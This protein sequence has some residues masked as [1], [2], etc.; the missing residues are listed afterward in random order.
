MDSK[1][2]AVGELQQ[3]SFEQLE[4]YNRK[5]RD[6]RLKL[7][8]AQHDK[9]VAESRASRAEEYE[10]EV[11]MLQEQN[12]FLEDKVTRLCEAPF[13]DGGGASTVRSD[14]D[15]QRGQHKRQLEKLQEV[16][17]THHAALQALQKEADLLRREKEGLQKQLDRAGAKGREDE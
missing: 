12:L 7:Q 2:K 3:G 9:E 5:I 10:E 11:R 15:R 1:T 4:E 16:A 17:S 6:L 8:E 13:L 14:F